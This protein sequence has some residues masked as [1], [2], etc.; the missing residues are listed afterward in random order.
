MT[1]DKGL[2]RSCHWLLN[3]T[4]GAGPKG[5]RQAPSHLSPRGRG[6]SRSPGCVCLVCPP[7][8]SCPS[9]SVQLQS[10]LP[11][12]SPA[13]RCCSLESPLRCQGWWCQAGRDTRM[14]TLGQAPAVLWLLGHPA[15]CPRTLAN[16]PVPWTVS[17]W[18][19]ANTALLP[20]PQQLPTSP[21]PPS[22]GPPHSP[23]GQRPWAIPTP[24]PGYYLVTGTGC[25]A[26]NC[27]SA[28]ICPAAP[29]G[30]PSLGPRAAGT[31]L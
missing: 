30:Q 7:P 10:M 26:G 25:E 11:R 17:V 22:D 18:H 9:P 5:M 23:L 14:V 1:W 20:A 28:C 2:S 21:C 29:G 31:S 16:T 27:P 8:P 3:G 19:R 15:G 4:Q 6:R 24:D 13:P 12:L